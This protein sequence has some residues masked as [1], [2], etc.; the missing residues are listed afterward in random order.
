MSNK[1]PVQ[2]QVQRLCAPWEKKSY[3]NKTTGKTGWVY[4]TKGD[5]IING[6]GYQAFAIKTFSPKLV[7][8]MGDN[9]QGTG[10]WS[11][12]KGEASVCVP[13][14]ENGGSAPITAKPT[15]PAPPPQPLP[16]PQPVAQPVPQSRPQAQAQPMPSPK[17]VPMARDR[18][19]WA[20]EQAI[21]LVSGY[22]GNEPAA[23][24][25]LLAEA[26]NF[27]YALP[28]L[29]SAPYM[30]KAREPSKASDEIPAEVVG[31]EPDG[32][33]LPF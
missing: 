5:V 24:L 29:L 33:N 21:K 32:D 4:E 18:R 11:E 15:P 6:Q 14:R 12:F 9:W 20:V 7:K 30:D 19:E 25:K 22:V 8:E 1:I 10:D 2:I 17:P 23:N 28:S 26:A 13:A 16:K 27:I 3:E 31:E